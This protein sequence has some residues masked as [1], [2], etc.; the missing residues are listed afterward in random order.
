MTNTPDVPDSQQQ[1]SLQQQKRN[2][3]RLGL[4]TFSGLILGGGAVGLPAVYT[5]FCNPALLKSADEMLREFGVRIQ[6]ANVL[7]TLS[8][9][10]ITTA[11]LVSFVAARKIR[12]INKK[13]EK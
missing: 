12:E 3:F 10:A 2:V 4:L 8:V 11:G 6:M 1:E 9:V 5:K 13:L 7:L